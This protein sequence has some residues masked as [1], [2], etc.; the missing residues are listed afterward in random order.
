MYKSECRLSGAT[1]LLIELMLLKGGKGPDEAAQ[2]SSAL[3]PFI[4]SYTEEFGWEEAVYAALTFIKSQ[5]ITTVAGKLDTK[6]LKKVIKSVLE[7]VG[8][9]VPEGRASSKAANASTPDKKLEAPETL[10]GNE[11]TERMTSARG[12]R[13]RPHNPVLESIPEPAERT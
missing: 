7:K 8:K 3:C 12:R 5:V 4:W 1:R 2:I 9:V 10:I 6:K 11:I 13:T